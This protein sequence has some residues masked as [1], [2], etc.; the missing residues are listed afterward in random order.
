MVAVAGLS[1][2]ERMSTRVDL[3]CQCGAVR[4]L[5]NTVA[6]DT[7]MHVVCMCDDCQA[8]AHFL[9]RDDVL[10]ASGG[11]A[12]FQLRP[13]QLEITAGREHLRCMRL[14]EK[15]LL[16]WYAGCCVW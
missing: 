14:S 15:G 7:G 11:T 5:A 4:G 13:A 3:R 6:P 1:Y 2:T 9:E 12:I 10:D 8:F 16:R